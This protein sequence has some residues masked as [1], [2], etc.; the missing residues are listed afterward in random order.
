M[1]VFSRNGRFPA[2][3]TAQENVSL[4]KRSLDYCIRTWDPG[5]PGG[6]LEPHHNTYDIEFWDRTACATS[7]Y[8]VPSRISTDGLEL[9]VK[10]RKSRS[11]TIW[12]ML[13]ARFMEEQL[14]MA[15]IPAKVEC[16]SPGYV[17]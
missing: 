13:C 5:S 9:L 3:S 10:R 8:W 7:I 6:C 12:P 4:A 14:L 17:R 15:S 2:T 16:S 1:K 11:T